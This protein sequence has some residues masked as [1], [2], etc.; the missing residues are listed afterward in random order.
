[1][2]STGRGYERALLEY[3]ETALGVRYDDIEGKVCKHIALGGVF[4]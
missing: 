4:C 1:M 3:I 2:R